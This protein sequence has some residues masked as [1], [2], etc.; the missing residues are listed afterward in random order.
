MGRGSV[1]RRAGGEVIIGGS[2]G[3]LGFAPGDEM[4]GGDVAGD[5]DG[6]IIAVILQQ[7]IGGEELRR[8]VA[9]S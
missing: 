9:P 4:D 6:D 1:D 3:W 7:S 8:V 5:D 2:G